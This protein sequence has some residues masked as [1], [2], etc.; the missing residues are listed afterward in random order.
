MKTEEVINI[1]KETKFVKDYA[2]VKKSWLGTYLLKGNTEMR[3]TQSSVQRTSTIKI[4]APGGNMADELKISI[5]F[6]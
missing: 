6:R 5:Q 1:M 4:C 3:R 2:S